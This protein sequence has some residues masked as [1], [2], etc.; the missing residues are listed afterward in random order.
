MTVFLVALL[1][2]LLIIMVYK[3]IYKEP[4]CDVSPADP[5]YT[6][7]L[8]TLILHVKEVP[9]KLSKKVYHIDKVLYIRNDLEMEAQLDY[10]YE[11]KEELFLE[12][13]SIISLEYKNDYHAIAEVENVTVNVT[14][15]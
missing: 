6:G 4:V 1:I 9:G 2:F 8:T 7:K 13:L 10:I 15:M 14:K 5:N 11:H 12:E 3:G